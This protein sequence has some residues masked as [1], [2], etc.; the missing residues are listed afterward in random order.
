MYELNIVLSD[1]RRVLLVLS[2]KVLS[3]SL[4]SVLVI[5][6]SFSSCLSL[7]RNVFRRDLLLICKAAVI[8]RFITKKALTD[9]G[10]VVCQLT[11]TRH[12][13]THH[14]TQHTRHHVTKI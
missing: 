10:A 13:V 6:L 1:L 11:H 3:G 5:R 8:Q 4:V 9:R 2:N 12:H 14:V 7:R